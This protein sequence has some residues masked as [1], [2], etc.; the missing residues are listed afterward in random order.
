MTIENAWKRYEAA[1]SKYRKARRIADD[2]KDEAVIAFQELK[3]A[4][5]GIGAK[6]IIEYRGIKGYFSG[7]ELPTELKGKG[8]AYCYK[9]CFYPI[10]KDGGISTNHRLIDNMQEVKVLKKGIYNAKD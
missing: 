2:L 5:T 3:N 7:W 9:E 4:E 1:L 10:K 8:D 6:D